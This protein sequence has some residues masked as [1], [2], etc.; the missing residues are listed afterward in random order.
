MIALERWRD[1]SMPTTKKQQPTLDDLLHK[2]IGLLDQWKI[3]YLLVGGLAVGV[4]GE[5][6]ATQDVDVI[7]AVP[8]TD[9]A[10]FAKRAKAAGF[11]VAKESL[12]E[13]P[14]T[15]ALRLA[16]TGLHVD[17]IFASTQFEQ[18]AFSRK[19]R[20]RLAG[21]TIYVPT[22]EDLILLKLVPGRRKDLFDI[23]SVLLRHRGKLDRQYLE[24][25]AQRLAD[26]MEDV[27]IWDT[28]QWVLKDAKTLSS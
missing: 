6:R 4:V 12:E 16:W 11:S 8:L 19:R 28:L 17:V 3:P 1:V 14:V 18:S 9:L 7:I 25:W 5:A 27:R 2:T 22:P 20:V 13:A 23:E 15:G 21:R 10:T 26:E 24:Q